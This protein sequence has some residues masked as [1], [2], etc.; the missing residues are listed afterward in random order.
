MAKAAQ[1]AA[2]VLS[3]LSL[4]LLDLSSTSDYLLL[5]LG[6]RR[7]KSITVAID[8]KRH[9]RPTVAAHFF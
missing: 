2:R 3:P 9:K 5:E 7:N 8:K 6:D 1:D 4:C